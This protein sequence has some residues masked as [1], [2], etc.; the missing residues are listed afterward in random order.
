MGVRYIPYQG[1]LYYQPKQCMVI[2]EIPQNY[3]RFV[4][5][6]FD[7]PK[8]GPIY[9]NDPCISTSENAVKNQRNCRVRSDRTFPALAVAEPV[10]HLLDGAW[11]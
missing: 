9:S 6:L 3:H 10:P 2:R 1:S 4:L 11:A 5:V 7:S 8:M